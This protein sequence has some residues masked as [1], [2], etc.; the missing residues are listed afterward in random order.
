MIHGKKCSIFNVYLSKD[1]RER[2]T[3]IEEMLMRLNKSNP[4]ML[5]GDFNFVSDIDLDRKGVTNVITRNK[6]NLTIRHRRRFSINHNK[7]I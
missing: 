5:G 3:F 2:K 1:A 7:F 6:F 4:F